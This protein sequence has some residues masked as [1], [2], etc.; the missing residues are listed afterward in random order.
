MWLYRLLGSALAF[1]GATV[2]GY[3]TYA[4]YTLAKF[5]LVAFLRLSMPVVL[6]ATAAGIIL[7]AFGIWL[8][9]FNHPLHRQRAEA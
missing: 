9:A 3:I 4:L 2:L 6:V 7:F 1:G 8:A 5:G